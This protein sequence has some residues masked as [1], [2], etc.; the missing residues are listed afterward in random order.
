MGKPGEA[1]YDYDIYPVNDI[2]V[3]VR[4]DVQAGEEGIKIKHSKF[5]FKETLIVEGIVY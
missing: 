5:M 3:H 1:A 4:V 2:N